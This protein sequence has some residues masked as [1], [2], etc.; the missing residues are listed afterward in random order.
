MSTHASQKQP[1]FPC[2]LNDFSFIFA[3]FHNVKRTKNTTL[4][5]GSRSRPLV[6]IHTYACMHAYLPY[7]DHCTG[8][9]ADSQQC[10]D[11]ESVVLDETL[12][13]DRCRGSFVGLTAT[14]VHAY[15]HTQTTCFHAMHHAGVLVQGCRSAQQRNGLP[16]LYLLWGNERSKLGMCW[17][18]VDNTKIVA[19]A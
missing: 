10:G 18:G 11:P 16:E 14:Y 19:G 7:V 5:I 4:L 9:A 1:S 12:R 3:I 6:H 2:I 13:C 15:I 8:K 17:I